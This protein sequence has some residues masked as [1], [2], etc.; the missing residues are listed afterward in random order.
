[1][2]PPDPPRTDRVGRSLFCRALSMCGPARVKSGTLLPMRKPDESMGGSGRGGRVARWLALTLA[3]L[4]LAGLLNALGA[5][6]S[7]SPPQNLIVICEPTIS[8]A[9]P[10]V[11]APN[12]PLEITVEVSRCEEEIDRLVV[13]PADE[14]DVIRT[15]EKSWLAS[16][17]EGTYS[18]WVAADGARETSPRQTLISTA[19]VLEKAKF[20]RIGRTLQSWEVTHRT[21]SLTVGKPTEIL[22][23]S[24]FQTDGAESEFT[25][26]LAIAELCLVY[27]PTPYQCVKQSL[28]LRRPYLP[29]ISLR[30]NPEER[31]QVLVRVDL[32]LTAATKGDDVTSQQSTLIDAGYAKQTLGTRFASAWAA[33][34]SSVGSVAATVT[35]AGVVIAAL[36]RAVAWFRRR[37]SGGGPETAGV[38]EEPGI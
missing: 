38:D 22:I 25:A 23:S 24:S 12:V 37:R 34:G 20:E 29:P 7:S 15:G 5:G 35:A 9:N 28:D 13:F 27:G 8:G 10:T 16:F 30:I 2:S 18:L 4:A 6:N 19:D 33:I 17:P 32:R 36:I 26:D 3:I 21:S 11:V 31:G 14:V 1:M